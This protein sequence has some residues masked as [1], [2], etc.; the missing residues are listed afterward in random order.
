MAVLK[1]TKRSEMGT[2]KA[3]ALRAQGQIPAIIYGHGQEPLA[4]A[5][6]EHEVELTI[7]HGE[8]L[9]EVEID[10]AV[11]NVLV[12]A[13][14]WDTFGKERIHLDLTRVD[15]D[16][17]VTVT[18]P[19]VLKGTPAG[20]NEGGML[21]QSLAELSI[22]CAVRDI[23]ED[24]HVMINEMNIGDSLHVSDLELPGGATLVGDADAQVCSVVIIEEEVVEEAEEGEG[25]STQPEVIGEKKDDEEAGEDAAS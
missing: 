18:I 10:G 2:R 16:E 1:A 25:D 8:R 12:K 3:R 21:Q 14:Q 24:V 4:V 23:P 6:D 13:V 19:I 9:L 5:M 11:Q 22:E 7:Q 15:L 17:R 20:V